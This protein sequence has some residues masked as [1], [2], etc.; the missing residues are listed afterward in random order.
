MARRPTLLFCALAATDAGAGDYR[1]QTMPVPLAGDDAVTSNG[2]STPLQ[3]DVC[4][5]FEF[6]G[7]PIPSG[8]TIRT[9][10]ITDA[11]LAEQT[12]FAGCTIRDLNAAVNILHPVVGAL[13]VAIGAQ[14]DRSLYA[15]AASSC[16]S[17]LNTRFDGDSPIAANSCPPHPV[18]RPAEELEVFDGQRVDGTWTLHIENAAQSE[19]T[20]QSWGFAADVDC[21]TR[22]AP[23]PPSSCVP[24]P[25]TLCLNEN[26]FEVTVA[27]RTN[28]GKSGQGTG[29][30]L[31]PDSGYFWFFDPAN[32][33]LMV[34]VLDA[35]AHPY[36]R[37]WVFSAGVTNVEVTLLV[38][39]TQT[40]QS[41]IYI[42]PLNRTYVTVN[43]TD[44]F[45]SCP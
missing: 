9:M 22:P 7:A 33:E 10:T 24:G 18:M 45:A 17:S 25:T 21:D 38:T 3:G 2:C 39:D 34:K 30:R 12:G 31:T 15:P 32:A 29:V 11:E 43:D 19:G 8:E 1:V 40:H 16:G 4:M 5:I 37:Y 23:P 28:Q 42:N 20:L 27:W 13:A 36:D 44:A 35:C 6:P 41:K 14:A 26:R